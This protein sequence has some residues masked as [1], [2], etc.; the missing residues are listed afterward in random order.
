MIAFSEIGHL[1]LFIALIC[2][3]F[4]TCLPV[5]RSVSGKSDLLAISKTLQSA[6]TALVLLSFTALL[7]GFITSDFSLSL[8]ATHS[9]SANR[10]SIKSQAPGG[11]MKAPCYYGL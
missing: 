4:Q 6:A 9:H 7:Y 11:I 10:L 8:V 5:M 2:T 3:C 1:A